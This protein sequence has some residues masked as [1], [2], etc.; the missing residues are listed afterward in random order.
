MAVSREAMSEDPITVLLDTNVF[1]A[2]YWNKSSAS[3]RLIRACIDGLAQAHYTPE[4]KR[5][6]LHVLRTI[7]VSESYHAWLEPFWER[8]VEVR[9][10]PV[11]V[12]AEDPDDQK[13][14]EA[15]MGGQTDFLA[16]NDDHL[17]R[18]RYVGRTEII[19][20]RSVIKT[21]EL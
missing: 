20:P 18:I 8:A 10:A 6:V 2:A 9:A 11:D 17:L 5:E 13:F 4:V 1:V 16:T 14:L 19:P 12:R 7:R 21:L 15:V 3:A